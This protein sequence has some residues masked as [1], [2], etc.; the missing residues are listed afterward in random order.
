M[1]F[2]VEFNEE[3]KIKYIIYSL[4]FLDWSRNIRNVDI[5]DM[6]VVVFLIIFG[7]YLKKNFKFVKKFILL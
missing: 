2:I 4:I 7:V 1:Y 3:I 5:F 6:F